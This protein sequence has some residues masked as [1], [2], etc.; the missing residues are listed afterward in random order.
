MILCSIVFV[1]IQEIP[2]QGTLEVVNSGAKWS[3]ERNRSVCLSVCLPQ[4]LRVRALPDNSV[5]GDLEF[6]ELSSSRS[7]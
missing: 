6:R 3:E 7:L 1:G 5:R 2:Q 4:G